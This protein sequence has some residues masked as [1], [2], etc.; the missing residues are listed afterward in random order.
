ML[1]SRSSWLRVRNAITH[2]FPFL[3]LIAVLLSSC[4]TFYDPSDPYLS[5]VRSFDRNSTERAKQYWL[6]LA[7]DGDCDAEFG[8]G[9]LFLLGEGVAQDYHIAHG[10]LLSSANKGQALAQALIAVMHAHD[11]IIIHSFTASRLYNCEKGCG[12]EKDLLVAYQ[13]M[14]L[15]ERYTHSDAN[16]DTDRTIIVSK[17]KKYEESLTLRQLRNADS[18]IQLWKPPLGQCEQRNTWLGWRIAPYY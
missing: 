5:G 9:I 13:W 15:S 17:A 1:R 10:W 2:K 7:M 8:M 18:G 11:A 3:L 16:Y 6:P 12:Y 14:R 4:A